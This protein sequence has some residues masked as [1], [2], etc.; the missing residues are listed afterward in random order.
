MRIKVLLWSAAILTSLAQATIAQELGANKW[1][2]EKGVWHYGDTRPAAPG[3]AANTAADAYQRGDYATAF[4]EY[5]NWA[6]QG[7]PRAQNMIGLMYLRGQGV[8]RNPRT[9]TEWLRRAAMQGNVEA[10]FHLGI[11][12]ADDPSI[13]PSEREASFWLIRSADRGNPEAQ[14]VLATQYATGKGMKRDDSQAAR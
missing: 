2:D 1:Q 6:K 11:L 12:Y 10:Q 3:A 5:M 13:A 7:D 9:A 14:Y 4:Q 8:M